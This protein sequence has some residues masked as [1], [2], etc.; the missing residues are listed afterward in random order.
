MVLTNRTF[1]RVRYAD[2]DKMGVVYN[3]NYLR[4]FEIGRTELIR[5]LGMSYLEMENK[6][7]ILPL[8]SAYV[9]FHKPAFYDDMLTIETQVDSTRIFA[10]IQFDYFIFREDELLASGY[11]IHS[12]SKKDVLKPVRPPKFFLE[13][14]ENKMLTNG[15][16]K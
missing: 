15:K 6:G 9:E 10:T 4:F 12:F 14:I 3:G 11:T 7:Y 1:V 13:F 2:I 5:S 8:I 16:I